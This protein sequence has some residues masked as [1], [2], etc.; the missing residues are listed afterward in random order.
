MSKELKEIVIKM[1]Q[2]NTGRH[3]LDSGGAYGRHWEA[4]QK[5]SSDIETWDKMPVVS[6][7]GFRYGEMWGTISLYHHLVNTLDWD[8]DIALINELYEY[9]DAM[10]PDESYFETRI[11]FVEWLQSFDFRK[12]IFTKVLDVEE[13]EERSDWLHFTSKKWEKIVGACDSFD[14]GQKYHVENT[15]NGDNSLSQNIEYVHFGD[16]VGV[17]IHNGCDARGGYTKPKFF[18]FN[19]DFWSIDDFTVYCSNTE[20]NH[21]WDKQGYNSFYTETEFELKGDVVVDY[22]DLSDEQQIEFDTTGFLSED[23]EIKFA[24]EGQS[25]IPG[26][27]VRLKKPAGQ[28]KLVIKNGVAYCP[29]CGD[30]LGLDKYYSG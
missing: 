11:K 14:F 13:S 25:I 26:F 19:D 29:I 5:I 2:E 4:N 1:L 17:M 22:K 3:M 24:E 30:K 9:F 23:P 7:T 8:E 16:F 6:P 20:E 10:F 21:Y 18:T 12:K 15:Y 28:K 27:D